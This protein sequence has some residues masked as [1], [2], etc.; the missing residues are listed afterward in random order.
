MST[1]KKNH[2]KIIHQ[3]G[4]KL[5]ITNLAEALKACNLAAYVVRK[6]NR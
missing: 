4:E 1:S 3:G 5:S 6:N 2:A